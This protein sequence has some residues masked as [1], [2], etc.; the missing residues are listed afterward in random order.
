VDEGHETNLELKRLEAWFKKQ[1]EKDARRHQ[2]YVNSD[3]SLRSKAYWVWITLWALRALILA[4]SYLFGYSVGSGLD[5]VKS[6]IES[7][8]V[9]V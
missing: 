4:L 5:E 8:P 9:V 2:S 3:G 1:R 6:L 7:M